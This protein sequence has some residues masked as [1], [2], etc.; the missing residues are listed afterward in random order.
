MHDRADVPIPL[1]IR[2]GL[3]VHDRLV[4]FDVTARVTV[5]ENPLTGATVT[6]EVLAEPA[7]PVTVAGLALVPKS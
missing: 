2:A 6:V 5:A 4:E 7:I 1:V 3:T